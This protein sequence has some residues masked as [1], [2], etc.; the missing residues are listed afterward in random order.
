MVLF[1]KDVYSIGT[2]VIF[3]SNGIKN[4]IQQAFKILSAKK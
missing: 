3:P 4:K 1:Y 2:I